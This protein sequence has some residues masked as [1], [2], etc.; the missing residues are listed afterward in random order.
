MRTRTTG[1]KSSMDCAPRVWRKI[2]VQEQVMHGRVIGTH[3]GLL[4]SGPELL[5]SNCIRLEDD[6]RLK[7][8]ALEESGKRLA[9]G[10]VCS[11]AKMPRWTWLPTAAPSNFK[12]CAR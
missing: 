2:L 3:N 11:A 6:R 4:D 7:V 1:A 8:R 10:R 12:R 5:R 9:V